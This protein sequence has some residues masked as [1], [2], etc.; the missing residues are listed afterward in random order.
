MSSLRRS[1]LTKTVS[2]EPDLGLSLIYAMADGKLDPLFLTLL[3]RG[4]AH[5]E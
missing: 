3:Y 5:W 2:A 4:A 1:G